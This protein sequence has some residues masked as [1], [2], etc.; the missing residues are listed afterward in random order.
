MV[1]N[2]KFCLTSDRSFVHKYRKINQLTT[3]KEGSDLSALGR[4]I[5]RAHLNCLEWMPLPAGLLLYA[6]AAGQ[7]TITDDLAFIVIDAI[8]Q[9]VSHIISGSVRAVLIRATVL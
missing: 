8:V 1:Y 4:R 2:I 6:I 3:L 7:T 9:S 5:A